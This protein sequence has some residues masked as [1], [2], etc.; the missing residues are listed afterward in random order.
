MLYR[1]ARQRMWEH[2]L[3]NESEHKYKV[4]LDSA[5]EMFPTDFLLGE[6]NRANW[7]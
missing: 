4:F 1:S 3:K 7:Q 6:A 2:F 5:L